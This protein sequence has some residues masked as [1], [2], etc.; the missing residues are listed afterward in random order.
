MT[1]YEYLM[2]ISL[3]IKYLVSVMYSVEYNI[4][5]S[6]FCFYLYFTHVPASLQLGF[7]YTQI[8]DLGHIKSYHITYQ[9]FWVMYNNQLEVFKEIE[10]ACFEFFTGTKNC[11]LFLFLFFLSV[12]S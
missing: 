8:Q 9:S 2:F 6:S 12:K 1:E 5:K 7:V 11:W 4:C 3:N 10:N